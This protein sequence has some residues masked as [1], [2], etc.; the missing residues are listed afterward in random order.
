[1]LS[2]Y[3][4]E[5]GIEKAFDG[6]LEMVFN[7]E[8]GRKMEEGQILTQ[9]CKYLNVAKNVI[10]KIWKRYKYT[11]W[12]YVTRQKIKV[13]ILCHDKPSGPLFGNTK[14]RSA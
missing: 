5:C 9:V 7:K 13:E 1:M 8:N 10:S 6:L 12:G 2:M 3:K 14:F 4:M 11:V